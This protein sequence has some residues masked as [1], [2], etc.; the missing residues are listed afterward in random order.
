[1]HYLTNSSF[2]FFQVFQD[3]SLYMQNA[4]F[5]FKKPQLLLK[6]LINDWERDVSEFLQG[7]KVSMQLLGWRASCLLLEHR[8]GNLGLSTWLHLH[9]HSLLLGK[10]Q[11]CWACSLHLENKMFRIVRIFNPEEASRH[12]L[13]QLVN[14]WPIPNPQRR[15]ISPFSHGG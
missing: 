1:M 14:K 8:A 4:K 7:I 15:L 13:K 12:L 2:I 9:V 11:A 6:I 5:S 10:S 3:I